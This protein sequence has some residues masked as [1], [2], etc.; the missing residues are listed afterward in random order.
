MKIQSQSKTNCSGKN[1]EQISKL[2]HW[3][4]L[5][6]FGI[7]GLLSGCGGGSGSSGGPA[8]VIDFSKKRAGDLAPDPTAVVPILEDR[9]TSGSVNPA[10]FDYLEVD[11][12][13]MIEDAS[14]PTADR[15]MLFYE[16]TAGD[17]VN[18]IGLISSDEYDFSTPII[19]RTQVL[20]ASDLPQVEFI[21]TGELEDAV[22]VSDPSVIVD[23]SIAPETA[24][25]YRMWVEGVYG[26]A[27]NLSA[28]L[29]CS[30]ADGVNWTPP[31]LCEGFTLGPQ[32]GN[33]IR[34][35]DADVVYVGEAGE[36]ARMIF[37]VTRSD[38]TSV[39][40]MATCNDPTGINWTVTDGVYI[41][42]EAAP[43]FSG[44]PGDFDSGSVR[45][46]GLG[47][48]RDEITGAIFKWHLFYEGKPADFVTN[49]DSVIGYSNSVDGYSWSGYAVPVITPTSDILQPS[50]FDT[51]DVKHPDIYLRFSDDPNMDPS[52]L[53]YPP[54]LNRWVLYYSG[55]PENVPVAEEVNRIG[56]GTAE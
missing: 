42:T 48:E 33:V 36:F 9:F 12:P 20:Q 18:S 51:D 32:F 30:S 16:A 14:R 41:E 5:T 35:V 50:A 17:G 4:V 28:I 19:D 22:A 40:G 43:V 34:V 10:D 15:Y 3:V 37:E 7:A 29:T 27:A 11:S 24:G 46:P 52:D 56:L 39:F 44:G 31:Q 1:H 21:Q 49:N 13:S 6:I 8:P 45:S 54:D 26:S 25:R 47:I 2:Q 53:S 38:Q 23:R 55:D